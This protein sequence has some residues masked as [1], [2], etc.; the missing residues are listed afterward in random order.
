MQV[1]AMPLGACAE[2]WAPRPTVSVSSV[3]GESDPSDVGEV[4]RVVW[5]KCAE[6]GVSERHT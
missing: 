1:V 2:E 5:R 3:M 4:L 6:K